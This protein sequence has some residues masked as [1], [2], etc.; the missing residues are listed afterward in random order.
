MAII[1]LG[2]GKIT[3]EAPSVAGQPPQAGIQPQV[4]PGIAPQPAI[5]PAQQPQQP[6]QPQQQLGRIIDLDT[7]EFAQDRPVS[8]ARQAEAQAVDVE[9]RRRIEALPELTGI[10][11]GESKAKLA[12]LTPVLLATTDPRELGNILSANFPNIGIQETPEGEILAFNNETGRRVIINKPG[13]SPIDVIQGLGIAAAFTP[14]AGVAAVPAKLAA[15]FGVGAA[16]AG[17]TQAAIEGIQSQIGGE[18][19]EE[20]I[21]V[22]A[23]LGGAAELVVPAIQAVR[24][25]RQAAKVGAGRAEIEQVAE[26]V[27]TARQAAEETGVP[28]FQAQQT[29]VPAQLEK[30]SFIAQLPAGTQSAIEGLTLQNKAAGDAVENF[31]GQIAPDSAVVTGAEQVR[32]A[33]ETAV[34]ATVRARAEAASPIYKQAFRRQRKGQLGLI[35]TAKLETKVSRMAGQFDPSGEISKNLTKALNKIQRAD[36][37]LQKLHLAKTELDQTINSFGADSVGNTT[38]RFVSDVVRDL[39]DNLVT[40]SP[41]YRAARSEFIRLS[42]EVTKIQESIIGKIANLDDTQLKQVT[43]KIFDP[44]NTVKNVR[45]AKKAITDVSPEAWNAIVR[46]EL[47]GRLGVIKSTA[48]AGTVENIPGQMFRAIFPNDKKTKVLMSALD[49][50]GRMNL[51]YLQTALRRASLGR[52]G[53]S[54]TAARE[55]IKRELRGGVSQSIRDLFK[56]PVSTIVSAGE[57]AAFNKR[58]SSLSKALFDPTWKAE[59]SKLRK[60][61][62]DT[63]AAGRAFTQLINSIDSTEEQP[64]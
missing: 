13:L 8:Q 45:D 27:A 62:A 20:E 2:S 23:A 53:G 61:K 64:R 25:S 40:Q 33:A 10:A 58:A 36:G 51:K 14:G 44:S 19:N 28:L 43:S 56:A 57:D 29:G 32:T 21:A 11:A 1:D 22:A 39:T 48:E 55:E 42:P 49:A 3:Q 46:R 5:A 60:L 12:A 50:E 30:Q 47:E 7:G 24:Q 18:L 9:R 35:N 31:L 6:Q 15:K 34:K 16:T 41:S 26:S 52:P 4:Q 59:M 38:K 54:Q 17:L 37:N 63:P